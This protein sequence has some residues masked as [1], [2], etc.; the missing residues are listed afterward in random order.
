MRIPRVAWGL[1]FC[2]LIAGSAWA[3]RPAPIHGYIDAPGGVSLEYILSLP[4]ETVPPDGWPVLLTYDGYAAGGVEDKKYADQFVPL[5]YALVGVSIRGTGCSS[6]KFDFFEPVQAEDGV[7]VIRWI[8]LQPWSNGKIAMIGK[9][10]PGISQLFVAAACADD[11]MCS[12]HLLTIAPGHHFGDAYR[13]VAYPGGIFNYGFAALWS[14]VSQPEPGEANALGRI[15]GGD[16]QCLEN[17][18][19]HLANLPYNPFVQAIQHPYDDGLFRE[20]SPIHQVGKIRVPVYFANAWQDEQLG[21]RSTYLFER[22]ERAPLYHALLGNGSH[23]LYRYPRHLARLQAWFD[24]HMKGIGPE[25]A[26]QKPVTV[27]FEQTS[28]TSAADGWSID[29]DRWPLDDDD[30]TP[31]ELRLRSGGRLTAEP[32]RAGEAPDVYLYPGGTQSRAG[33]DLNDIGKIPRTLLDFRSVAFALPPL[34]GF[35]ATYVTEP[36]ADDVVVLGTGRAKLWIAS[37]AVD[38][39]FQ[40]SIGD[41]W[42]NGDVEYVQKGWLRA[43]HRKLVPPD[44]AE[45]SPSRY[46]PVH[47]HRA[48]DARLLTPGVPTRI[49]VEIPPVG[50]VF[51]RGH[52]IR[53]DVEMPNV[54]PELWASVPLPIP[55]IELVYHDPRYPSSIL[56]PTLA[57]VRVPPAPAAAKCGDRIRQPCRRSI[58]LP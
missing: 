34:P 8:A 48:A 11:V 7:D 4:S 56:L 42:P 57:A 25:P 3:A 49:D 58:P 14:F 51:R 40:V 44:D 5:G 18:L 23:G 21:P 33:E 46:R 55:A 50:Q 10:F 43:S 26:T 6:G 41:V 12:A 22:L 20:R 1:L 30:V 39:D 54:L 32:A 19:D 16:T 29:L 53:V 35:S 15:A 38:T 24:Y 17:R 27:W 9:S 2:S 47:S 28:T 31:L 37:T 36:L 13:D 52:R 45:A